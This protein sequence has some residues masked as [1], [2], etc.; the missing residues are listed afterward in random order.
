MAPPTRCL[1][2]R[3]MTPLIEWRN[4]EGAEENWSSDAP[5]PQPL[6]VVSTELGLALLTLSST[7]ETVAYLILSAASRLLYPFTQTPYSI[8]TSLLSSSSFTMIWS[9]SDC[10]IFNIFYVRI[11]TKESFARYWADWLSPLRIKLF[12]RTEDL[13][14]ICRLNNLPSSSDPLIRPITEHA[15]HIIEGAQF[16][17]NHVVTE[18]TQKVFKDMEVDAF[19]WVAAR[20]VYLLTFGSAKGENIPK[21]LKKETQT[22]IKKLRDSSQPT[23]EKL[24][25]MFENPQKFNDAPPKDIEKSFNAIR[26]AASNEYQGSIFLTAS[27]QKALELLEEPIL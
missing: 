24:G 15:A 4:I 25:E 18:T 16:L 11:I 2:S 21:I 19:F 12:I 26:K 8:C 9:A 27:Y 6:K 17:K 22:A 13:L 7:I 1:S 14:Y 5:L 23:P 20:S 10:L 3:L